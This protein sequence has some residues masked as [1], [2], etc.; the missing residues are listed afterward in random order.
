MEPARSLASHA[1]VALDADLGTAADLLEDDPLFLRRRLRETREAFATETEHL[2][3]AYDRLE[4]AA[5]D[6]E[7]RA[8]MGMFR[9]EV[10]D[11]APTVENR[12]RVLMQ[13]EASIEAQIRAS[14]SSAVKSLRWIVW[15][16]MAGTALLIL[17]IVLILRSQLSRVRTLHGLIP[18]CSHCKKVRNDDGYWNQVE[19][20]VSTHS[21]ADFS[22][23]LC[24]DCL[25]EL[26]PDFAAELDLADSAHG[27]ERS[28]SKTS[29]DLA[30]K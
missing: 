10:A 9:Q 11:F 8:A 21:E 18:I 3:E 29:S 15:F 7:R 27:L 1:L 13:L 22:H 5:T 20:Y 16:Q 30:K 28:H 19:E 17:L 14:K 25:M 2:V 12:S 4:S 26:Y 24:P 23:G 6:A